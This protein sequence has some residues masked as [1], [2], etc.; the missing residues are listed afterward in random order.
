[1]KNGI[2]P[3]QELQAL[4][5]RIGGHEAS[6]GSEIDPML[7]QYPEDPRLHFLKGSLLAGKG[8][9]SAAREVM[10]R[11]VDLAPDYAVARFQ[12]GF[13]ALTCGEPY[14]AQEVWGPLFSLAPDNCLREFAVGLCH[15]I[16]DEFPAAIDALERGISLNRDNAPMNRDMQLII[17]AVR[18]KM[19]A[20]GTAAPVSTVDFLLQ[21]ANL[22]RW[23]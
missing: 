21:Q 23:Q 7:K 19:R 15:L 20:S 22:R 13:L 8:D 2:C 14:A 10:R 5:D 3:D 18:Q 16:H 6:A 9:Y 11:A 1:M 4:A 17:E 12:L